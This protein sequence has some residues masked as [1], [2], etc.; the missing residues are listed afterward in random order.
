M[1][2]TSFILVQ[3]VP[4]NLDQAYFFHIGKE[5]PKKLVFES[6]KV[7]DKIRFVYRPEKPLSKEEERFIQYNKWVEI[8]PFDK[9]IGFV[10]RCKYSQWENKSLLFYFELADEIPLVYHEPSKLVQDKLAVKAIFANPALSLKDKA[11]AMITLLL[12]RQIILDDDEDGMTKYDSACYADFYDHVIFLIN[13]I[14]PKIWEANKSQITLRSL[15][16]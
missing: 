11:Q 7:N 1:D 12:D 3:Q 15:F 2:N 16:D 14:A 8:D 6:I 13:Q 9:I 5:T 10:F 4:S